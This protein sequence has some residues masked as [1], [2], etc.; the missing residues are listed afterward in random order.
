MHR[1]E[2]ILSSPVRNQ[3]KI[4]DSMSSQISTAN[5]TERG[6]ALKIFSQFTMTDD[7]G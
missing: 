6:F 2:Q 7:G 4:I 3:L 5:M 1:R